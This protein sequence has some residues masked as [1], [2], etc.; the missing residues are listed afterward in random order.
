MICP[1]CGH[2]KFDADASANTGAPYLPSRDHDLGRTPVHV[3][4]IFTCRMCGQSMTGQTRVDIVVPLDATK[5]LYPARLFH[6]V[7]SDYGAGW[8][9]R[10]A[11][12][13]LTPTQ[14]E[15]ISMSQGWADAQTYSETKKRGAAPPKGWGHVVAKTHY[16]KTETAWKHLQLLSIRDLA[17]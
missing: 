17:T 15:N 16:L 5:I 11:G 3:E 14:R 12:K 1:I 7:I 4:L 8:D 13:R 9:I 2:G 10:H 6:Q